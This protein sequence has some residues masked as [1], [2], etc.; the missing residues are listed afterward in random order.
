[1]SNIACRM[2]HWPVRLPPPCRRGS[3]DPPPSTKVTSGKALGTLM[4][5]L[6]EDDLILNPGGGG[7]DDVDLFGGTP[8]CVRA[9]MCT[10]PSDIT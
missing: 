9:C 7:G 1:M 5:F 3:E 4:S 10:R 8:K 2:P 6:K